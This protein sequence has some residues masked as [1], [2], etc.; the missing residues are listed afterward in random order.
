ML[1]LFRQRGLASVIYGGI[2]VSIIFV[3][4]IQFR[5]NAGQ[6]SASI[7]EACVATVRG[8]CVDP[9]DYR[10]SYRLLMPRDQE[11]TPSPAQARKMG[12]AKIALDGLVERELL[13]DEAERIGLKVS[14]DEITDQIFDGWIRVSVPAADPQ[15]AYK[16]RVRDGL[17]YAGFK[18][19]KTKQFEVKAYERQLRMIVGRS[20]TEFRE[21]QGREI[22]AAKMRDLITAP[23]R[24][25]DSEAYD[26]Y[27]G[28]K[29][30]ASVSTI[31]VKQSWVARWMPPPGT[32]DIDAWSHDTG[33]PEAIEKVA[34]SREADDLPKADHVRH[35]LI[36]TPPDPTEED[37]RN[38]AT[39]LGEARARIAAG[40]TFAE[41]ARA[42]SEDKGSAM[43]GGDLGD[44]LDGFVAPFRDAASALKPG[45]MT[46]AI[47]TQFGLHLITKDDPSK[48][49]AVKAQL[50][51][52]VAREMTA[53]AL[54]A[55]KTKTL[56]ANLLADL[57]S[58]T[59]PEDAVAKMIAS[60]PKRG[61]M[62]APMEIKREPKE[63]MD[64]GADATVTTTAAVVKKEPVKP[65]AVDTD[66]ER[67]QVSPGQP[68]NKGGDPVAGL[69]PP[70]QRKLVEFAFSDKSKD[71]DWAPDAIEAED[72]FVLVQL[73][74]QKLATREE[75]DK[76]KETF[77]QSLLGAK[78]AEALSLHVKRLRDEA[79][80]EYKVDESYL[81][82][83]RT[84]DGG[85]P[86]DEEDEESP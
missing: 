79:K 55:S 70:N 80:N 63:P 29:S 8:W 78:R 14:D 12:L 58:G 50:R 71:G 22:L 21:E 68:F 61:A 2:I 62:P 77:E 7:K 16:L 19:P 3:F 46:V 65:F 86:P 42:L 45:E 30:S 20:A 67:P 31:A 72:G 64:G 17:I 59:K 13:L 52:D 74:D 18:D 36:K 44:K 5:P 34:A 4:V 75:F 9:K 6:K 60:M 85:A 82:D 66:P 37:L 48:E 43:R 33:N 1:S 76:E 57:K 49:A 26:L 28:Q 39:R 23:I 54:A 56:T 41:V 69:A 35:I 53:Q 11:G 24:V 47:Q 15:A 84:A 83:G 32:A 38:A 81:S 40:A 51:K 10:A 25:S 27:E 73:T